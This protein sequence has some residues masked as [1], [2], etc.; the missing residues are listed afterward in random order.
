VERSAALACAQ[1]H[2]AAHLAVTGPAEAFPGQL[3]AD[4]CRLA[5]A[6]WDASAAARPDEAVS[7]RAQ[8]RLDADVEKSAALAPGDPAHVPVPRRRLRPASR[9]LCKPGAGRF[10]E[11]SSAA[12]RCAAASEPLAPQVWQ[13][14][15]LAAVPEPTEAVLQALLELLSEA[16]GS[17]AQ[18]AAWAELLRVSEQLEQLV[19]PGR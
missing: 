1:A 14:V 11:Q 17:A 15:A 16:P 6:A 7:F 9:G 13:Q 18:P 12:V 5:I 10:A 8:V 2:Q 3:Q 4:A 19:Q